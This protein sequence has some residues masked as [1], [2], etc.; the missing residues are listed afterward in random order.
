MMEDEI[1]LQLK[2]AEAT[3]ARVQALQQKFATA[4]KEKIE[5]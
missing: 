4:A 1:N 5:Q 2:E 3:A